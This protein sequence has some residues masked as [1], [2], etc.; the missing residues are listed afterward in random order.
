MRTGIPSVNR[1]RKFFR[2]MPMNVRM[3]ID[4]RNIPTDDQLVAMW[5]HG[6]SPH[7]TRAYLRHIQR[8]RAVADDKRARSPTDA[9]TPSFGSRTRAAFA[10]LD[11]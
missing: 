5:L 9:I 6:R 8:L 4:N 2:Y 7:T 1:E 11:S 10:S 3:D